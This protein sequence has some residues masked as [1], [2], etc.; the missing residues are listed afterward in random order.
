MI[1]FPGLYNKKAMGSLN[2]DSIEKFIFENKGEFGSYSPPD[3][4][5]DKFLF[6]LNNRIRHF[7]SIVPYLIRVAVAT[8]MIFVASVVV[9]NNFIR[10]DRHY[11]ALKDKITL[12]LTKLIYK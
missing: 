11:I 12:V 1:K 9:W 4:H 3:S 7:V 8:V 10:K 2:N 6:K 5:M